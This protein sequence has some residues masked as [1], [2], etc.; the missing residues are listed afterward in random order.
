MARRRRGA[1]GELPLL[2]DVALFIGWE[3]A[4]VGISPVSAPI[5]INNASVRDKKLL[6]LFADGENARLSMKSIHDEVAS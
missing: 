1:R 5:Y 3:N 4:Y 6:A 2:G